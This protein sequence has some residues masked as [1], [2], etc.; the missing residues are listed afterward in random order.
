MEKRKTILVGLAVIA[1]LYGL[2]MVVVS[3]NLRLKMA[4]VGDLKQA[5]KE[6][7]KDVEMRLQATNQLGTG[8]QQ[9]DK[10]IVHKIETKWESNPFSVDPSIQSALTPKGVPK[11]EM[12]AKNHDAFVYSAYIEANKHKVAVINDNEYKVGDQLENIGYVLKRI[13]AKS[14]VIE[15]K[16]SKTETEI[17]FTDKG[18]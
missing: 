3:T 5:V 13:T 7:V 17:L 10:Y 4:N 9:D 11:K 16:A 1:L 6:A 2:Y 14:V 15:H 12:E 18:E 8:H